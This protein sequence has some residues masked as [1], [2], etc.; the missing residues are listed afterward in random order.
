[1]TLS[2]LRHHRHRVWLAAFAVALLCLRALVP[3]GFMPA[4]ASDG[5]VTLQLCTTQGL[6]QRRV[7]V[8]PLG[9]AAEPSTGNPASH[10]ERSDCAFAVTASVAPTAESPRLPH[11][12]SM[13]V[14]M[15]ALDTAVAPARPLVRSHSARGPPASIG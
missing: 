15:V 1:V 13:A 5:W 2:R 4:T 3:A 14:V 9:A 8:D 10:S 12:V 6:E 7:Q 11:F